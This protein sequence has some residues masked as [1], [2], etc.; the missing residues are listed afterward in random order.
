MGTSCDALSEVLSRPL[1]DLGGGDVPVPEEVL[2]L[3]DIDARVEEKGGGR[4]T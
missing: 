4:R 3:A 1:V 2:D